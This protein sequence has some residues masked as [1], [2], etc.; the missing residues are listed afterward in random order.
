MEYFWGVLLKAY[1]EF[2]ER[3]GEIDGGRGAKSQRVRKAVSRKITPFRIGELEKECPDVSRETIRLVLRELKALGL[4]TSE[5]RG[6]GARWRK[7]G[8]IEL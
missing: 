8:N 3:V 7:T 2:E 5:G 6:P 4:V 1:K